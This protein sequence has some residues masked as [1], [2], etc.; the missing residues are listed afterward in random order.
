M[1]ANNTHQVAATTLASKFRSK[2]EIYQM[3]TVEARIYCAPFNA[4]TI[5]WLRDIASGRKRQ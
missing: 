5:Y 2:R 4:V 1:Q 3:L